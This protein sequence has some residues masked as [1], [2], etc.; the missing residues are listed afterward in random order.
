MEEYEKK[1]DVKG[2][3]KVGERGEKRGEQKGKQVGT[4]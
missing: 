3:W 4:L 2:R 1:E